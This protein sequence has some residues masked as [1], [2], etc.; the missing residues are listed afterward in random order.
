MR[1]GAMWKRGE[2]GGEVG[3]GAGVT[4]QPMPLCSRPSFTLKLYG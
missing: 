3:G 4:V 2:V 1:V